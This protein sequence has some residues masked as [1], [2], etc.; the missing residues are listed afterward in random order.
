ME[1][2]WLMDEYPIPSSL[3]TPTLFFPSPTL[4]FHSFPF[5]FPSHQSFCAGRF[6]QLLTNVLQSTTHPKVNHGPLS[7]P[8]PFPAEFE[9]ASS[10][11][12]IL[13]PPHPRGDEGGSPRTHLQTGLVSPPRECCSIRKARETRRDSEVESQVTSSW[14]KR[15]FPISVLVPGI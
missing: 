5:Y 2:L 1:P 14:V 3:N 12:F 11:Y 4:S 10:G 7:T 13:S 8:D 9:E 15:E 6:P